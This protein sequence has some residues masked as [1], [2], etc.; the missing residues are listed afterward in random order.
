M[1]MRVQL[2][3]TAYKFLKKEQTVI[4]RSMLMV[5][6]LTPLA[7]IPQIIAIYSAQSVANLSITTWILY[8]LSAVLFLAY[9]ILH[10]LPPLIISST[11][12]IIVDSAVVVGWFIFR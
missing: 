10:K 3:K 8:D 5:G 12:W 7:T 11:L 2:D 6:S 4:D 9:A 1:H